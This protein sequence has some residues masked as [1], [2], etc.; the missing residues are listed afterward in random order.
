M[1]TNM[2][3]DKFLTLDQVVEQWGIA[4]TEDEHRRCVRWLADQIHAKKIPAHKICRRLLMDAADRKAAL[5]AFATLE[6]MTAPETATP[7]EPAR[8]LSV[9][10][11][12]RST[13]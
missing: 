3:D 11:L 6:A 4:D 1:S 12:R 5:E 7:V 2:T 10:S 9:A 8:G 13:A